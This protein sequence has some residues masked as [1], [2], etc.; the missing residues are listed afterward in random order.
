MKTHIDPFNNDL[1]YSGVHT[2]A[3][4]TTS[5]RYALGVCG[6]LSDGPGPITEETIAAAM[7]D[8]T[9]YVRQKWSADAWDRAVVREGAD[10]PFA[11]TSWF[12]TELI[13]AFELFLSVRGA[14]RAARRSTD[15]PANFPA[16]PDKLMGSYVGRT[17]APR[18]PAY[19]HLASGDSGDTA[20]TA[21][22]EFVLL[23]ELV[24]M[25][26]ETLHG[27]DD[28]PDR[29]DGTTLRRAVDELFECQRSGRIHTVR[30]AGWVSDVILRAGNLATVDWEL[31][32][33][34]F[35]SCVAEGLRMLYPLYAYLCRPG[36]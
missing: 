2:M 18:T 12:V 6:R 29:I 16:I 25:L 1:V 26:C 4:E 34:A 9:E 30:G 15:K 20:T 24:A 21:M 33:D 3:V 23:P 27:E 10:N 13:V 28:Q 32:L 19:Y 5:I 36:D 11:G 17:P 31:V 8:Q 22:L 7:R 14:I 35:E